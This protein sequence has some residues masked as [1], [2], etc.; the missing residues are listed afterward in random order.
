MTDSTYMA[1]IYRLEGV[2]RAEQIKQRLDSMSEEEMD[3]LLRRRRGEER[4]A[5]TTSNNVIGSA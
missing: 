1:S 4:S 2:N 5:G 3:Q